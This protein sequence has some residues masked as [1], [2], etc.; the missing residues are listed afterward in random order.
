MEDRKIYHEFHND[1][2]TPNQHPHSTVIVEIVVTLS[3]GLSLKPYDHS[4][5]CHRMVHCCQF[6][7]P[8]IAV[9]ALCSDTHVPPDELL[10][11]AMYVNIWG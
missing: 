7:V 8:V 2:Q 1:N 3:F 10:V 6:L 11:P 5:Y 4:H 9:L